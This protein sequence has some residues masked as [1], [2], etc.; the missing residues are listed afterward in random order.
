MFYIYFSSK[1]LPWNELCNNI[2][3]SSED[4][5]YV[6]EVKIKK[7]ALELF[8]D[9][10]G[11]FLTIILYCRTLNFSDKPNYNYIKNLLENFLLL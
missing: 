2:K 5:D 10:P 1:N 6:N 8:L 4:I 9:I 7:E 11:E 3:K